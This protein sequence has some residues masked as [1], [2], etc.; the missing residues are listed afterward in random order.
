MTVKLYNTLEKKTVD[1][2]PLKNGEV[3]MYVCGVTPYDY[4]HIGNAR[5]V[6]AFDIIRRYFEYSGYKVTY[7]QNFTDIDD[8]I[9]ARSAEQNIPWHELPK[10]FIKIYFEEMDLLNV[11]RATKYPL[12]TENIPQIIEMV[13]ELIDKGHAYE[14]GGDVYYDVRSFSSYGKLSGRDIDDMLSGARVDVNDVKR[15]PLDFALWKGAKPKEPSWDSPW[16]K[17]RPGWHIECSAMSRCILGDTFDIH[18]GGQDLIFPHHENEIAQSEGATGCTFA[19]YWLHNGFVTV[20]KEKMSK[21][22]KNF[23]TVKDVLESYSGPVLRYFLTVSHYRSP[24]DYSDVSLSQAK[25]SYERLKNG[26]QTIER[27]LKSTISVKSANDI[28]ALSAVLETVETDF[29]NAMDDDFNTPNA[30]SALFGVVSETNKFIAD[31]KEYNSE[32]ISLLIKAKENLLLFLGV[33]GIDLVSAPAVSDDGLSEKLIELFI[34]IRSKSKKDKNFALA[35]E[36][37]D[38]LKE[39][40]IILEDTPSGTVWKKDI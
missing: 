36:I 32:D 21:S 23:F 24:I 39:L 25:A 40:G 7:I 19:K 17:G 1:F 16:G 38:N 30:I 33:L 27:A 11:K 15:D 29:K 37:R 22:L 18:C 12:A 9:I 13:S 26:V 34:S 35:D 2:E 4:P 8:K 14:S 5:A 3:S 10:K 31:A 20:N 6:V 28:S